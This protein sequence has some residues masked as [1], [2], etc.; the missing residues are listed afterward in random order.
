[1]DL[2]YPS[3]KFIPQGPGILL[4]LLLFLRKKHVRAGFGFRVPLYREEEALTVPRP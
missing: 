2:P 1:V 4:L 3:L